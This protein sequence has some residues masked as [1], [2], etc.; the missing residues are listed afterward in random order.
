MHLGDV[1]FDLAAH[2]DPRRIVALGLVQAGNLALGRDRYVDD[3]A[4]HFLRLG[5]G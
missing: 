5:Q 4:L 2:R 3:V 1:P